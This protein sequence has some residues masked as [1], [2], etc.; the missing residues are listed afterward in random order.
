MP[1]NPIYGGSSYNNPILGPRLQIHPEVIGTDADV[2]EGFDNGEDFNYDIE[3]FNDPDLDEVSDNIDVEGSK[4]VEHVH[5][6]SFKNPSHGIVLWNNRGTHMLS[7]DLDAVHEFPEYTN[8]VPVHRL[9]LSS[10]LEELFVEK[11]F[12]NKSDCVFAI[13]QYNMKL[14]ID[15][16]AAKSTPTLYVVEWWRVDEGC[17]WWVQAA[18][19]QRTQQWQIQKLEGRHT[20]TITYMMQYHQKLDAKSIYN[21]FKPLMKDMPTISVSVLITDMQ[22][23]FQYSVTYRKAWWVK[24][25]AMEQLY[26]SWDKSY[27]EIQGW[28][29]ITL[30]YMLGTV[31]DL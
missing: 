26:S 25:M 29:G 1:E 6:P 5:A 21:C 12:E 19:I 4:E 14:P 15:Y 23:W 7:V 16:N 11:R 18:F 31:M 17:G 8:I 2:K 24:Q 13:E 22:A 27:N 9:A 3:D 28:I 10:Q 30:G 20:C